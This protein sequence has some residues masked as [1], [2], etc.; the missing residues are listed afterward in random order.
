MMIKRRLLIILAIVL[1]VSFAFAQT[2]KNK[3]SKTVSPAPSQDSPGKAAITF[4]NLSNDFGS[5]NEMGGRVNHQFIFKNTGNAP[6]TITKVDPECGC[7]LS[8]WTTTEVQPGQTGVVNAIF[9]PAGR[10]GF[11]IKHLTVESN[12][13]PNIV[14]LSISGNVIDDKGRFNDTYRLVY[15]HLAINANS[16]TFDKITDQG[17]DSANIF[18]Y[19]LS[20]RKIEIIKIEKPDN[21]TMSMMYNSMIPNT[22]LMIKL[23]YSPKKH[24]EYGPSRQEIK[25]YTNDD[26][27]PIKYFY[28]D[29][30]VHE[31]FSKLDKKALKKAPKALFDKTI[32]DFGSISYMAAP[33][34]DFILSNKGKN[35]LI[36]RR[37]VRSCNCISVQASQ[38]V[39]KKGKSATIKVGYSSYNVVGDDQREV[40][41]ITN[42]PDHREIVLTVKANITN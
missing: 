30:N 22:D 9:N 3:K 1:Q 27:L 38:T 11:F 32:H 42:D 29:A 26:T 2:G 39:I 6:L 7:T 40:T 13:V 4:D 28:V 14:S 36:I 17:V 8:N 21:I 24:V 5:I 23:K 20:N 15:G 25:I 35:D 37:I 33:S 16:F 41:L 18:M 31:D 34:T 10:P 19:N 12:A